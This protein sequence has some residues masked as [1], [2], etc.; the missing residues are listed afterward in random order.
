[1]LF[2]LIREEENNLKNT[3]VYQQ[4]MDISFGKNYSLSGYTLS[5]ILHINMKKYG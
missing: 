2:I 3:C 1:M 5:F 4:I